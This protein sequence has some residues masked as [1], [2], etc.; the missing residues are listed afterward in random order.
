MRIRHAA[1]APA[2]HFLRS[3][4]STP[5]VPAMMHTSTWRRP[6]GRVGGAGN[7]GRA[8][9]HPA[10]A[11]K[12]ANQRAGR[13]AAGARCANTV[14][15]AAGRLCTP[16]AG[17]P[18]PLPAAHHVQ[19]QAVVHDALQRQ[20]GLG[21]GLRVL[22]GVLRGGR[23]AQRRRARARAICEARRRGEG[24]R[25]PPAAKPRPAHAPTI[26]PPGLELRPPHTP[27][28]PLPKCLTCPGCADAPPPP[29]ARP[30]GSRGPR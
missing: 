4:T 1:A 29:A 13:S 2:L 30:P 3:W 23:G 7:G 11:R 12:A 6:A 14:A 8:G 5:V 15:G 19:E 17:P 9:R 21:R 27:V 16:P 28:H 10:A 22:D 24:G 25:S 26:D 18:P 20:D